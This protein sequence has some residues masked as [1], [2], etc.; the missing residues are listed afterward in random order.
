MT[1]TINM[2]SLRI[3]AEA[4]KYLT[5]EK[6]RI[7]EELSD[8][9]KQIMERE[10]SIR[11]MREPL[12]IGDSVDLEGVGKLAFKDELTTKVVNDEAFSK[13]LVD[14]KLTHLATYNVHWQRTRSLTKE[15][16]EHGLSAPDGV[17]WGTFTK[18]GIK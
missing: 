17:E 9:N 15:R 7:E 5:E 2:Q 13:W 16:I 10:T 11:A 18:V 6:R 12:G 14:N 8:V 4:L 1:T 3:E